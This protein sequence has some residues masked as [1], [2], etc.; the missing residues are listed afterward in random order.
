VTPL[1]SLALGTFL[2]LVPV[3][4]LVPGLRELVMGAHGG[5]RLDA[6]LFM[7]V[8]MIAGMVAIPV[9][10]RLLSRW[11]DVRTWLVGLL[12]ADACVFAAMAA[13]PSVSALLALRAVDGALHLPAVTLLM[14]AANRFA[15]RRRGATLGVIA[16]ALMLGVAAGAPLGGWL[17]DRDPSLV[18]RAGAALLVV[19]ALSCS[20]VVTVPAAP[21]DSGSSSRYRWDRRAVAGWI[22]LAYGFMDRFTIGVFV[23]TFTLYL[24]EVHGLGAAQRG[25]LMSLFLLPFAAL[26]YPAGRLADRTGWFA[27]LLTGNLLFGVAYASYGVAPLA[28]LPVLMVVSGILAALMFAP[29]LVLVAEF[30]RRGAGEGLFGAFQVAGSLGFL[31]GPIVGG[32]LVEVTRRHAGAVAY[33]PIF[34]GVGAV[35]IGLAVLSFVALRDLARAWSA[36]T[37]ANSIALGAGPALAGEGR[38]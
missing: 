18:Y 22:P 1:R 20:L 27:P 13:A 10:M 23:S 4:L 8:N 2:T 36:A 34:A 28:A 33:A 5:T 16:S 11:P 15:G 35:E 21:T 7:S 30:A 17:V 9:V 19:A 37:P 26:C 32:V 29:N 25:L 31:T 24:A 6:H 12:L 3:T 14:V 38:P